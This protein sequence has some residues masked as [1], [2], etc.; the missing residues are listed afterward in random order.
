MNKFVLYLI[1]IFHFLFICFTVF[2]PFCNNN[3]LLFMHA[4]II[5]FIILHWVLNDNTCALSQIESHIRKKLNKSNYDIDDC[6]T[7][8]IINPIYDFK[9]NNED[10]SPF[11]YGIT[12]LLWTISTYKLYSNYRNGLFSLNDLMTVKWND[13]YSAMKK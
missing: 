7:C 4:I 10:S 13:L 9:K 6:F 2:V 11:I 5:P 12:I 3:Y 1:V 8:K